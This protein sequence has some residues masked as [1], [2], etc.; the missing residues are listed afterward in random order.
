[1]LLLVEYCRLLFLR[2]QGPLHNVVK[3]PELLLADMNSD[4]SRMS[5]QCE[6][7]SL[8]PNTKESAAIL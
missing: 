8:D 5:C 7:F 1:M 3:A 4:N 2:Q 6:Y